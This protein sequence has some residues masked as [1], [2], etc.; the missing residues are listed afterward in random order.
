MDGEA[1]NTLLKTFRAQA[2]RDMRVVLPV[3]GLLRRTR[4]RHLLKKMSELRL[5]DRVPRLWWSWRVLSKCVKMS[6][7]LQPCRKIQEYGL[8]IR[9]VARRFCR[10]LRS[11]N[12]LLL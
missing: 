10:G 9:C 12:R 3:Q 8:Q 1:D 11:S 6:R 4:L 7:K 5:E 2:C